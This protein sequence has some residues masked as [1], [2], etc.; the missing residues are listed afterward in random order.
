MDTISKWKTFRIRN[1]KSILAGSA[2]DRMIPFNGMPVF[3][4]LSERSKRELFKGYLIMNAEAFLWLEQLLLLSFRRYLRASLEPSTQIELKKL[5]REEFYHTKA[6]RDFL[7]TEKELEWKNNSYMIFNRKHFRNTLAWLF[8]KFPLALSLPGAKLESYSIYYAQELKEIYGSWEANSLTALHKFHVED[9]LT[10][11]PFQFDFYNEIFYKGIGGTRAGIFF[12][13]S[14]FFLIMQYAQMSSGHLM[15][16]RAFPDKSGFY[17]FGKV[18]QFWLWVVF[19]T[20]PYKK[21]RRRTSELFRTKKPVLRRA[22]WF[23]H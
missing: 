6:F 13:T 19:H 11:V 12:A 7:R 21:S 18:L 2:P 5:L 17:R 8:K 3:A 23:L 4:T 10:H 20:A 14:F 9:E 15:M 22:F 1:H 16:R